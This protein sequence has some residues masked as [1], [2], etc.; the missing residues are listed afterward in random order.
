MNSVSW[1]LYA[2]EVVSS[3]SSMMSGF[4]AA[5]LF[6]LA[7]S[8]IPACIGKFDGDMGDG[9]FFDKYWAPAAKW[10]MPLSIV[11]ILITAF[12]PSKTTMYAIAA[13]QIGEQ[14]VTSPDAREMI[15][16]SKAI[17][18]DYLKSL[19]KEAAK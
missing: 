1:F 16:D 2:A 11:A 9:T 12:I 19:K 17:L 5:T 13:S 6:G 10:L 4:A 18:R 15:D 14:V 3:L 8:A 7:M